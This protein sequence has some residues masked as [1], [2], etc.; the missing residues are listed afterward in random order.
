MFLQSNAAQIPNL[1]G[2]KN[3]KKGREEEEEE[4]KKGEGGKH[5]GLS[6]FRAF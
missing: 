5:K 3:K 2:R 4:G 6:Y 1:Q